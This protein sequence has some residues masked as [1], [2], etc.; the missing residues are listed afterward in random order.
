MQ[1]WLL[2]KESRALELM[3]SCLEDTF[4]KS[5][6]LRCIQVGLLCVQRFPE[7]RPDISSAVLMLANKGATLPQLKQSGF[8]IERSPADTKPLSKSEESH[9]ENVVTMTMLEGR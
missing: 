4:V 6:A 2:W 3:N 8:F 9:S 1:A 5:E 7:D